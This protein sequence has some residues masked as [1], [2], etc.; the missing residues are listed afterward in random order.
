MSEKGK[1]RAASVTDAELAILRFLWAKGPATIR[2]ITAAVYPEE[3]AS[4]YA[5]V[6]KLLGRLERKRVVRRDRSSFAHVFAAAI[7]QQDFVGRELQ[8]VARKLGGRSLTSLLVQLVGTR[9]LS[10]ADRA[11]LR[12]ILED[13]EDK[14]D[15]EVEED[16]R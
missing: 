3:T 4:T 13:K 6:Q 7:E 12:R 2:D 8:R 14:E 11:A 15:E 9:K 1:R 5:T 10:Q 16:E